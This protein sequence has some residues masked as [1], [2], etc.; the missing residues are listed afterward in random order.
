[1]RLV[2]LA[3][4]AACDAGAPR[5]PP[6]PVKKPVEVP[7]PPRDA[8]VPAD[9]AGPTPAL[10]G[11]RLSIKPVDDGHR[12]ECDIQ[13]LHIRLIR[14]GHLVDEDVET[15]TCAGACDADAKHDGQEQVDHLEA[16][17]AAGSASLGELDYNFTHC[18]ETGVAD[19]TITNDIDG[20]DV[21]LIADR[22]IGPHDQVDTRYL[23]AT[24]V[25]GKIYVSQPFGEVQ[26]HSW[27]MERLAVKSEHDNEI[28]VVG[29]GDTSGT[30][31]RMRMPACP[32]TP[33]EDTFDVWPF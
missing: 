4:L 7:A 16:L 27:P 5:T 18:L 30:L 22:Y 3:L 6:E 17:V 12:D 13:S 1:M 20:R 33:T 14:R 26:S 21:A 29:T 10:R 9:A 23:L 32:G 2:A 25:C 8:F 11:A 19:Y 24:E 15:S 31:F 28:L